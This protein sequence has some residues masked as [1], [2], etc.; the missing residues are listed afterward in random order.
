MIFFRN[1]SGH[2]IHAN[3]G[4]LILALPTTSSG[5]DKPMGIVLLIGITEE[6]RI[7]TKDQ[8]TI[9]PVSMP[10]GKSLSYHPLINFFTSG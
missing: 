7:S 4:F 3:T 6:D 2:C 10:D 8:K 1:P 5:Q 9:T